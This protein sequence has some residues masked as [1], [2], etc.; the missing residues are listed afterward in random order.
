M[1][2]FANEIKFLFPYLFW[3]LGGACIV[4]GLKHFRKPRRV[5]GK[6]PSIYAKKPSFLESRKAEI[7][8][9]WDAGKLAAEKKRQERVK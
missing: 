7:R 8:I 6:R 5:K 3:I 2:E 1:I 9:G 4:F